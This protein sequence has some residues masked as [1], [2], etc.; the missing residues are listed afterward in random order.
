M[1]DKNWNLSYLPAAIYQI[2]LTGRCQVFATDRGKVTNIISVCCS[3]VD[4]ICYS[5]RVRFIDYVIVYNIKV[6]FVVV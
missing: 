6:H 4:N 3:Y 5:L 2:N 1:S